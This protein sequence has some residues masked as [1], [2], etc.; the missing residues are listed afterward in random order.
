MNFTTRLGL[1]KPDPDPVTGDFVDV[2]KLNDNA[3][4]ID[5]TISFTVC[6]SGARPAVPFQGQAIL[7]TDT[8]KTFIWGGSA[9]VP[10]L[11]GTAQF[12]GNIG[13]GSA[14]HA[15]NLRK[16]QTYSNGTNGSLSQVL[17]RQLGAASGSRALS[18]MGG[19]D[20]QDHWF[21][22][23]DGKMQWGP[24]NAG[25]DT[26]LYRLLAGMLKTDGNF[27]VGGLLNVGG[28]AI[29][30]SEN[31]IGVSPATGNYNS[32]TY[33]NIPATSSFSFTKVRSDTRIKVTLQLSMYADTASTDVELAV[34]VNGTDYQVAAHRFT[35]VEYENVGGFA[36]IPAGVAAGSYT[37]Q[38]RWRRRTGSPAAGILNTVNGAN[39]LNMSA[40]EI[41]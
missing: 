28:R 4:D 11:I 27:E 6:T 17:L 16:I 7:E 32:T 39:W 35:A 14:A 3:D 34:L 13:L 21:M 37:I 33:G 2:S 30:G 38:G 1:N 15:N 31:G 10:L 41:W 9:W 5:A 23:F 24:G 22:D 26:T 19:S 40:T 18:T 20:S 25:A 12:D 36:Y 29:T 8:G